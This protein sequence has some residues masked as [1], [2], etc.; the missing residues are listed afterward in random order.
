M[1]TERNKTLREIID[2]KLSMSKSMDNLEVA[3]WIWKKISEKFNYFSGIELER[4]DYISVEITKHAN[5]ISMIVKIKD[6]E[7]QSEIRVKRLTEVFL[8]SQ[9]KLRNID[10]IMIYVRGMTKENG[11]EAYAYSDDIENYIEEKYWW[12]MWIN[13]DIKP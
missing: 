11:L 2:S 7:T 9:E 4:I 13:R 3:R 8:M 6:A 5:G 12:V 10:E 1:A